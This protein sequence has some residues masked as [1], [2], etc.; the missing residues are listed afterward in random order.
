MTQPPTRTAPAAGDGDRAGRSAAGGRGPG[1]ALPGAAGADRAAAPRSARRWVHAVD[2]VSFT[3]ARGEMLALVG[4]SG[5]G[6]TTT[7]QTILGMVKPTSGTVRLNGT[8]IAGLAERQMR[9]LRRTAAD[10]LPGPVRVARPAVPGP[11][12]A[13]RSRCWCTGS[14]TRAAER[15][16]ADRRGARAGRACPGARCSWT[17]TRTSCPA[18]SAS[19]WRSPPR[20][21]SG[22]DLL[23]ADEPVS[24][25]DVS[26]R[27]GVLALLDGLRR[28]G[29]HGHPHDHP[30]PVHGRALR[31]P[32]RGDVPGPDRR[33]RAG[34]PGRAQSAAPL[35]QGA[36]V[37]RAQAGS[38]GAR[39]RRRS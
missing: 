13:S 1:D 28:D 22:R 20:W 36:A 21:C 38:P 32:D 8:D 30:R 7:A 5:C 17:A 2:G 34:P 29:R 24:M 25:L 10:D 3:L 37:G 27:A 16:G 39:P 31:R 19:G 26:V 15:R 33:A 9:P 4:E 12:D 23:L 35:H 6:K 14:A 18:A 11:A